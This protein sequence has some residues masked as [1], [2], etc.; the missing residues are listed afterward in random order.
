MS[1][2][3]LIVAK[4]L[5]LLNMKLCP[6]E[7]MKLNASLAALFEAVGFNPHAAKRDERCS[8]LR[9]GTPRFAENVP[10]PSRQGEAWGLA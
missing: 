6:H 4:R 8:K 5:E 7:N 10:W 2:Y 1:R 9:T 3:D